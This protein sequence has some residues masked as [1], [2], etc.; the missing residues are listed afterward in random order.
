VNASLDGAHHDFIGAICVLYRPYRADQAAGN[1]PP[2][3]IWLPAGAE[4]RDDF[5]NEFIEFPNGKFTDQVDATTQF[6]DHAAEFAALEPALPAG[7]AVVVNS[8]GRT[9]TTTTSTVH[10]RD[11]GVAAAVRGNGQP[12]TSNQRRLPVLSV[13][14]KVFY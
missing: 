11:R 10:T 12:I 14:G 9:R 1:L 6:L 3:V 8:A 13:N 2:D 5:I 7:L 4:W